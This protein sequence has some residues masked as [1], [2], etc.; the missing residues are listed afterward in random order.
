MSWALG[1]GGVWV[2]SALEN[3]ANATGALGWGR[4][5]VRID[6]GTHTL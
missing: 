3:L 4:A 5:G 2:F 6:T 1:G